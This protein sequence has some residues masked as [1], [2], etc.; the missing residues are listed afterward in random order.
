MSTSSS[1]WKCKL[2]DLRKR[3][4]PVDAFLC[5]ASFE[6]RCLSTAAHLDFSQ[7]RTAHV[8]CFDQ[9]PGNTG[10]HLD[11]LKSICGSSSQELPLLV[12]DPIKSADT[13]M[14]A[15]SSV[16][17]QQPKTLAVDIST[18]THESVLV[19]YRVI[20]LVRRPE[21]R[22]LFLYVGAHEY[23]LGDEEDKKWL[24]QGIEEVR[25]VVGFP[26]ELLPSR[27]IHLVLLVGFEKERALGLIREFEPSHVSLGYGD[28]A[29]EAT[30]AHQST[31]EK[32]LA[33]IQ[34]A[35]SI[36]SY[37]DRFQFDPFSPVETHRAIDEQCRKHPGMNTVIAPL[38]TKLSTLGVARFGTASEA[39]QLCYAQPV[40]Y[41]HAN[42]SSPHDVA[43]CFE[44]TAE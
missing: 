40:F 16:L 35:Q 34:R 42:Y 4:G 5:S 33:H 25:S 30:R 18:F 29:V 14:A 2:G 7:C 28:Q 36:A 21:T 23:S 15:M 3:I 13:L 9:R 19:L 43:W 44:D 22:I 27:S 11:D 8:A 12:S 41:N 39:A 24:S 38:N 6:G 31:N 32:V 37:V 17:L 20:R 1:N 10:K 26:G